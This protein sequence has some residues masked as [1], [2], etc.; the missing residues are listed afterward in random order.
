MAYVLGVNITTQCKPDPSEYRPYRARAGNPA[1][2]CFVKRGI[3][4]YILGDGRVDY[5]E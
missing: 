1:R 5:Q 2:P 3:K 4:T